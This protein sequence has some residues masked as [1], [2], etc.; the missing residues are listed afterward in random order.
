MIR[1]LFK[2]KDNQV[3]APQPISPKENDFIESIVIL[4]KNQ[5]LNVSQELRVLDKL[6]ICSTFTAHR[7]GRYYLINLDEGEHYIYLDRILWPNIKIEKWN[8]STISS[9]F[10]DKY[11]EMIIYNYKKKINNEFKDALEEMIALSGRVEQGSP[12]S[13]MLSN[14]LVELLRFIVSESMEEAKNFLESSALKTDTQ[15]N[16]EGLASKAIHE[17]KEKR[18]VIND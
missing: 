15:I 14:E 11:T 13:V 2:K 10:S 1:K 6:P 16:I 18:G 4:A 3:N 9:P 17:V 7:G 12:E 8:E 5:T